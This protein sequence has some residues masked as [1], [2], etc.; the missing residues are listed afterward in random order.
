M[1]ETE[2]KKSKGPSVL[3]A[4]EPMQQ[5]WAQRDCHRGTVTERSCWY[6]GESQRSGP[7]GLMTACSPW[8]GLRD[9]IPILHSL[10]SMCSPLPCLTSIFPLKL[11]HVPVVCLRWWPSAF[12]S[13]TAENRKSLW[14]PPPSPLPI[15]LSD[16]TSLNHLC[17]KSFS[18]SPGPCPRPNSHLQ[19]AQLIN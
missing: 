18:A 3:A 10:A 6:A 8:G 17:S 14:T 1:L 15:S 5:T 9:K 12:Q 2:P 7:E 13:P 16:F 11:T 19:I 4:A